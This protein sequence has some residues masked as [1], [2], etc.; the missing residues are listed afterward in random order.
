MVGESDGKASKAG[1]GNPGI[2]WQTLGKR[3]GHL[4]EENAARGQCVES[5]N[6]ARGDLAA[7]KTGCGAAAHILAGLAPKI[8]I[9]RINPAGKLCAIVA[10]RER[11]NDE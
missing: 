1:D 9:E 7:H 5:G 4:R 8:S 6:S 3:G 2:A 11:L 10:W